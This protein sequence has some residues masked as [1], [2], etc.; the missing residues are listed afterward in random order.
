MAVFLHKHQTAS[1]SSV[2]YFNGFLM[3]NESF[4]QN[5]MGNCHEGSQGE[6]E[7]AK[8]LKKEEKIS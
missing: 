4:V 6:A 8:V 3:E 7:R 5:R 2:I 1:L